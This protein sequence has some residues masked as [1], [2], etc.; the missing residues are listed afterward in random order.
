MDINSSRIWEGNPLGF[1]RDTVVI[2][3]NY[4]TGM[5]ETCIGYVDKNFLLICMF[6]F[7]LKINGENFSFLGNVDALVGEWGIDGLGA[8][9]KFGTIG[10]ASHENGQEYTKVSQS[11]FHVDLA[12]V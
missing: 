12:S 5:T 7:D 10:V 8:V 6:R 11:H 3:L 4:G 2:K 9:W 1:T